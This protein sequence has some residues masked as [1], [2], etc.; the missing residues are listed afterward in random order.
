MIGWIENGRVGIHWRED[1][2]PTGEPVLFLNSLGTDLR[3]WDEILP[4]LGSRRIIRMDTRGHGLSDAPDTGYTLDALVEDTVAVVRHLRPAKLTVV[5]VSLGGMIAQALALALPEY[6][7]RLILSNTATRMGNSTLWR[8]RI[9][10]VRIGGL[11][12]IADAILDRWFASS[13]STQSP[14]QFWRNML[15]RTPKAGYIGCCATLAEADLSEMAPAISCPSLV[16]GG[17]EDGASPPEIVRALAS[18]IPNAEYHEIK[19]AGHLPM[20]EAPNEFAALINDFM[21]GQ[22][23]V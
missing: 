1:G 5:G 4:M 23:H 12:G 13:H 20:A 6:V 16:I 3:L 8:Q 2:D 9:E 18:T 15:A 10:A 14:I 21:E 19:G 22:K 17:S 7:E 11:E